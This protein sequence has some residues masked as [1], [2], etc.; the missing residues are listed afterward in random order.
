MRQK[1]YYEAYL[2]DY[3]KIIVYMSR[4]SYDGVSNR[5]YVKDNEGYI[6]KWIEVRSLCILR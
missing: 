1:D 5:F 3:H 4:N 2:D 6:Y